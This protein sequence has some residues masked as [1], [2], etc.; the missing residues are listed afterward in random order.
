[1][2]R[3]PVFDGDLNLIAMV[4][5]RGQRAEAYL[6]ALPPHGTHFEQLIVRRCTIW[7][8]WDPRRRLD[9]FTPDE[10]TAER[11]AQTFVRVMHSLDRDTRDEIMR[12]AYR[13]PC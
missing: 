12:A 4:D 8:D 10:E 1:M 5:D 7:F 9:I 11:V 6:R 2:R 3:L 13:L